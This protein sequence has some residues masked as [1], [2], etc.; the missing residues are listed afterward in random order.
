MFRVMRKLLFV[1]VFSFL[2]AFVVY[3]QS[4]PSIT[5]VNN[6]GYAIYYIYVSPTESDEWGEDLLGD[7]ILQNGATFSYRLPQPLSAVS[8]YDFLLEDEDE[9][10]YIKWEIEVTNNA[11]IVFTP[12]DLGWD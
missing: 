5:I 1:C 9:D 3:A 12:D 11:R 6:T 8:L 4:L 7:E 2:G 10:Y